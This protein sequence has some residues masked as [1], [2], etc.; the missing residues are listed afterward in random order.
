MA[1][2][3]FFQKV[4]FL[5]EPDLEEW[6]YSLA[7]VKDLPKLRFDQPVTIIAGE[8]GSGKSTIV[9]ALALALGFPAEGGTRNFRFSTEDTHSALHDNLRL[10]RG[11]R[12]EKAGFFLRG[13]TFY[14]VMTAGKTYRDGGG[15]PWD[16]WHEQSHGEGF[17]RLFQQRLNGQGLYLL[18]EPESALSPSR[19]FAALVLLMKAAE[20]G[21]QVIMATH[22]PVLMAVPG[23]RIYWLDGDGATEREWEDLEH[24]RDLRQFLKDPVT[25]L[26][27]LR[28]V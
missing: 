5:D 19:Q 18:D 22:S 20:Q 28:Q 1:Y 25:Y 8:N 11:A 23:A 13:E 12:R 2:E 24:V 10:V 4:Q 7:P 9:E 6:P 16:G 27:H 21:A 15:S 3:S 14:N 26:H 17:F